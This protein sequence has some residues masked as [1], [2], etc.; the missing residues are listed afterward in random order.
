MSILRLLFALLLMGACAQ[1]QR[2][3][4]VAELTTFV[5]SQIKMKGDDRATADFLSHKIKLTEKLDDRTV[6]ELQ[7]LGAGLNTVRAPSQ[8]KRRIR[9]AFDA[10]PPPA[11]PPASASTPPPPDS[12]EQAEALA[13]MK[14]YALNYTRSLPNYLCVQTTRRHIDPTVPGYRPYGD[15]VQ[16]QLTFFDGKE[17]Y[18]VQMVDSKSVANMSHEQLGGVVSSGEFGTMLAHIFDPESQAEF[19]WERWTT[20]RGHRMY[21]FAYKGAEIGRIQHVSRR[22]EARVHLGV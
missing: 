2:P 15:V 4:T 12:I 16:E 19:D 9:P 1:A 6:E 8:A 5:K 11:A 7:G 10:A 13:A 22:I 20:L 21:V 3:M 14:E 18:K 17:T